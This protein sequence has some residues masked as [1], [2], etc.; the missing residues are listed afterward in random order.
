MEPIFNL[1]EFIQQL[2]KTETHL[3][4]E[5]SLPLE[6]ARRLD[7]DKFA[8]PP[9]YWDPDFRFHD[10]ADFQEQFDRY[11]FRW[12]VS[13]ENYY[14]SCKIVFENLVAQNCVYLEA[15]FHLG[16]AGNLT[17]SF[18]E[19]ARAIHAA[20]PAELEFRLF[21]GM[22]RDHYQG[23]F[24][25]VLDEAITWDEIAGVDLHGFERPAF[26]PWSRQVWARVRS[27]GKVTKAHA[28]E[29]SSA[30]D[31]RQAVVDLGVRR[32]QHGL[33]AID[34]PTVVEILKSEGVTLDMTPISNVKLKAVSSM[35]EHPVRQF[36]RAGINCT[37]STD[38]PMLFGN[39]L[40]GEYLALA[41]EAGFTPAEL[42]QL[43]R[44]GFQVAD[45]PTE[46]KQKYLLSLEQTSEHASRYRSVT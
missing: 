7:P 6:L 25:E 38:D 32:V 33:R 2:P 4:L 3:H 5:G 22:F 30:E 45:L 10:F 23:S 11:F 15:S 20:R 46:E 40:N 19:V 24:A 39:S 42:T 16:V 14:E 17:G 1:T 18:R 29:F 9:P 21:L 44:N 8:Q 36:M 28:G 43:A 26:Q 12:F 27:L 13:P 34:D 41:Q 37:I 35:G 31:V